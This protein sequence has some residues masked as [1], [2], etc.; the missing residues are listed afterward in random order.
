MALHTA[1]LPTP[2]AVA[3]VLY[4][5]IITFKIGTTLLWTGHKYLRDRPSR[6]RWPRLWARGHHHSPG[7]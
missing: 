3:A 5:R 6:G 4:Y 1:R 2:D 7:S